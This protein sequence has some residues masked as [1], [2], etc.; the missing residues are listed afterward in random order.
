MQ[1]FVFLVR[2]DQLNPILILLDD[3]LISVQV[4][5]SECNPGD[6]IKRLPGIFLNFNLKLL[7]LA[8]VPHPPIRYQMRSPQAQQ[9]VGLVH[10]DPT[11]LT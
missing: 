9:T 6:L 10:P 5:G 11:A 8:A 3:N 7:I 2:N 1:H 4:L